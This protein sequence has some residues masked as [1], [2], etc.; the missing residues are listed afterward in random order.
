LS[1][2]L[3]L[4]KTPSLHTIAP[5]LPRGL[6]YGGDYNPEQWPEEVWSEDV[7][8]MRDAGVNLV[9]VGIFSWAKLEPRPGEFNFGWLDRVL[10]LLW[11]NEISVCLAN[12]TASPPA[13]LSRAHPESLPVD[14]DGTRLTIGSRQHYCPNSRAYRDGAAKL[15]RELARRYDAH[16]AVALWHVN[17]EIGC[18][19]FECFCDVCA[20]EFRVWLRQRYGTLEQLNDA[21][22]TAFWSQAYGAWDEIMP[23]RKMTTIR[24]P[25]QALDYTR[26]MSDAMRDLLVNE[27]AAIRAERPDA[28]VAM[29]GMNFWRPCDG[30]EW[31]R[32]VDIA[33]WDSYPDPALGLHDIRAAAFCHDLYRSLR[34]GQPFML[35]EQAATQVNWRPT[36][37]LKAPG[38]MRAL[39]Y[40]AIAHGAEAVMFFQWR[41][42]KA[43]AEKFHSGMVPHGGADSRT[44]REVRELGNELKQ[45]GELTGARSPARVALLVSW[46]NRWALELESKPT[47]FDYQ[48]IIQYFHSAL[49]ELNVALDVA[50]PDHVLEHYEVVIAPALYQLTRAQAD[51]LRAY[52]QGGGLLILTYFSGIA[53]ERDHIWT[54]GYPALLQDVLGL[55]VEEWQPLMPGETNTLRLANSS[56]TVSCAKFCELLQARGAEVIATYGGGFYAGRPAITR[57]RFGAG[58]ACYIA[59]QP[60]KNYLTKLFDDLL[61]PRGIVVPVKASA[62]V[63]VAVRETETAEF[64]FVIN[65][66]AKPGEVDFGA[67][68]GTDLLSGAPCA[69]AVE[70]EPFGVRLVRRKRS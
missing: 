12:A 11:E 36:N 65:H 9:T 57:H 51:R 23:P 63:E 4:V 53:D 64:L 14:R 22:G 17:N 40:Q 52:V 48:E 10:G 28:K 6:L 46:E 30:W 29:N 32:H 1:V 38:Q 7:K 44:Y 62:G 27:V 16:P 60:E 42:S 45:L 69:G 70:L 67:W 18:H 19:T 15:S 33:A 34:G 58:E 59:T 21:W 25:G 68:T 13:W 66:E 61:R 2:L 5:K 8:L 50:H 56:E 24:N 47:I 3:S 39:S 26:F 49:W 35:M 41:A 37:Q 43:G 55:V 20:A 31:Y 54:G